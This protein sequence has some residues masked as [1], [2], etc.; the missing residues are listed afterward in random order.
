MKHLGAP[1]P[2]LSLPACSLGS[3]PVAFDG[4]C[5]VPT[6]KVSA[7][8]GV[9]VPVRE[10]STKLRTVLADGSG[11]RH[12]EELAGRGIEHHEFGSF[13]VQV[14]VI[15][16][17]PVHQVVR[18][19]AIGMLVALGLSRCS[20]GESAQ[21]SGR[22]VT[23]SYRRIILFRCDLHPGSE[24]THLNGVAEFAERRSPKTFNALWG[25]P[26]TWGSDLLPVG[27]TRRDAGNRSGYSSMHMISEKPTGQLLPQR[28]AAVVLLDRRVMLTRP[29]G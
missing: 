21:G 13:R 11:K 14:V 23:K 6:A 20:T 26:E 28:P 29:F 10:R 15:E 27:D 2:L 22:L 7:P 4:Q 5:A 24:C 3:I 9:V 8:G 19:D 12:S 1:V 25:F 18:I 17:L 16:I